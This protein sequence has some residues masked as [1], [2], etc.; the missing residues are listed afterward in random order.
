MHGLQIHQMQG[1]CL[2]VADVMFLLNEILQLKQ[3]C[4][5]LNLLYDAVYIVAC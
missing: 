1:T 2:V 5:F 4:L 3:L